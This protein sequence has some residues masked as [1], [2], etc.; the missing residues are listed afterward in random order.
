M[1]APVDSADSADARATTHGPGLVA[2]E[3]APWRQRWREGNTP[4]NLGQPAPEL[5]TVLRGWRPVGRALVPGCGHGHEVSL[6]QDLGWNVVGVDIAPEALAAARQR[7]RR[8]QWR[9][10]D[11]LKPPP[12]WRG[13]FDL[14]LEHTCFCALPPRCRPTYAQAVATLLRSGGNFLGLFWCHSRPDGPPF[15]STP[16][17]L[18]TCFGGPL[19]VVTLQRAAHSVEER[20]GEE[21]LGHW[22]KPQSAAKTP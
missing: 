3:V 19:Q 18:K 15:G 9:C 4:W 8:P 5:V 22:R 17:E 2:E 7:D 6:L 11:V 21:W 13:R 16:Q 10:G 1:A 14:V 12:A 20:C